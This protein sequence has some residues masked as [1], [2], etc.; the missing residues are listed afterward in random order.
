MKLIASLFLA[1]FTSLCMAQTPA[2]LFDNVTVIDGPGAP[3]TPGMQ[4][5]TRGDRIATVAK[6]IRPPQGAT[7]VDGRGKY[8]IYGLSDMHVHLRGGK[9]LVRDNESWLTLFLANGVTSIRDMGGDLV[10]DVLRWR[11]GIRQGRRD[12]P[13]ILT[14]GPKLD[15]PKPYW[16]GSI[17]ITTPEEGRAAVRKVK[18]MGADFVKVYFAVI[19]PE[20]HTAILEEAKKLGLPVTGHLPHNL[21]FREVTARGQHLEHGV[22]ATLDGAST[23]AAEIRAAS[24][25]AL[26]VRL[27]RQL[28]SFDP[29][30]VPQ[31]AQHLKE[32]GT[33]VTMTL[34]VGGRRLDLPADNH[35]SHPL[36]K[37]IYPGIWKTWDLESGRR[38]AATGEG[39]RLT[40]QRLRV[41]AA[42]A[43]VYHR[44]GVNIM[45]GSDCGASNN[46]GW[47]GWSL[48]EELAAFAK[49]G[50]TPL[51][52][53]RLA[54]RAPARFLNE[55]RDRG[56]VE[57]GKIADLVLL[58]ANPLDDIA[59]TQKINGVMARGRWHDRAALDGLLKSVEEE[60]AR[61]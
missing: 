1:A 36:R 57:P 4:V 49:S 53:L 16:P 47:P 5:L 30:L 9:E 2:V 6:R 48:H 52:A 32:A 29:N 10:E 60:A 24:S 33:W 28:E 39:I 31:V 50:L 12:G 8:L 61:R 7:V 58:D 23:R 41:A 14:C 56:T 59:N 22:Y 35:A 13:R 25:E 20:V 40:R 55:E 43:R 37:Y 42:A 27:Q 54:T 11:T 17:A 15:G 44:G 45:A 46:F 34:L 38:K 3:A 21:S 26:Q 18:S 51:E 19:T